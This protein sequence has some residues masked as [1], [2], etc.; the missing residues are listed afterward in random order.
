[1][2]LGKTMQAITA[3]R[4]LIRSGEVRSVLLVCPKPLVTNWK[5]EFA[6]WAPELP[7]SVIEGDQDEAT[8]ALAIARRAR[9]RSPTMKL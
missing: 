1:M 8:L 9:S 6:M 7:V 2:G 4:M 5:R 3:I